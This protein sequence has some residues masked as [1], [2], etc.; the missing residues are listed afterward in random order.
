[1]SAR[2]GPRNLITDVAGLRVGHAT[3]ARV[4]TG[5]TVVLCERPFAAAV[6]VRGG[7]P[8]TRET[9]L[10]AADATVEGVDAICLSGGSVYGL[11]AADGVV[12]HLAAAGRGFR[13]RSTD[14]TA[15]IVPGAIL[16]DLNNGG[17]K[18]WGLEP[19]YHR[20]GGEALAAAGE[21][22]ALGSVGAGAGAMAGVLKGGIGS[23]SAATADGFTVG[24]LAAVNSFGATT[25]PDGRTFWAAPWEIGDEFGALGVAGLAGS[26]PDAWPGAKVDPGARENTTV[27]VVATDAV[28]SKAQCKRVAV[29]AQDGLSRAI[30]PI[31]TGFDGDVVFA[32]ATGAR[33][34]EGPPEL[35]L[36]RLGT[37]AADCLARAVARGVYEATPWAGERCWRDGDGSPP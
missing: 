21:D 32:L 23:A 7:A 33:P 26:A 19:P 18:A 22:F 35:A 12:A 1:M 28:L 15:P 34:L 37:L 17:D 27:A 10:L 36:A 6:D 24:A 9:D 8:G 29:M 14:V 2:P 31:H 4:R 30:R 5:V 13:F 16:F 20:L 11:A 25:G 3:D